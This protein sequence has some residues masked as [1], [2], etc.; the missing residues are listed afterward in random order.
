[1]S[2]E[3]DPRTRRPRGRD[4]RWKLDRAAGLRKVDAEIM[5]EVERRYGE[6]WDDE[7]NVMITSLRTR[8]EDR[9]RT[10]ADQTQARQLLDRMEL[11]LREMDGWDCILPETRP[12]GVFYWGSQGDDDFGLDLKPDPEQVHKLRDVTVEG[13]EANHRSAISYLAAGAAVAPAKLTGVIARDR[14]VRR[15]HCGGRR[16]PGV[17]RTSSRSSGGGSSGE[18]SDSDGPGE[19]PRRDVVLLRHWIEVAT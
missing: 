7:L 6:S 4:E 9:R 8:A 3:A 14:P 17:R 16:R 2:S 11:G 10:K 15:M 19:R 1:M 5:R 18:P 13:F 12:D